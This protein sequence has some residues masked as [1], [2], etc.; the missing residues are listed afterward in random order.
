MWTI[1]PVLGEAGVLGSQS[2]PGGFL[3]KVLALACWVT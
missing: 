1:Y 3:K 2:F